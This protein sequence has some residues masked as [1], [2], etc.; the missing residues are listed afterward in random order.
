MMKTKMTMKKTAQL[1]FTLILL[2]SSNQL[3]AD[4][5]DTDLLLTAVNNTTRSETNKARDIYRH[6]YE[7]LSFFGI[8]PDMKVLE[9]LPGRGWYTEILAPYLR[10]NGQL[11]IASFGKKHKNEYLRGLHLDLMK[12]MDKNPAVYS[13]VVRKVFQEEKYLSSIP[14]GSMDMVVTFRNTH[15]WIRYGGIE[16]IYTAFHRVLKK[17]GILGVVQHR[18]KAGTDPE[19]TAEQGYVPEEYLVNFIE[20]KGFK[21][22]ASSEVNANPADTKDHPKGVWTLPPSF[23]LGEEDR[24]TYQAIGES[25]RMTLKFIKQ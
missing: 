4:E 17:G 2:V 24:E 10:N 23:R 18:A 15:N 1:F 3:T 19:V 8:R 13:K 11:T 16:K 20:S 5:T 6:P 25:D 21:L 22:V 7:T 12:S 9:I 14:K